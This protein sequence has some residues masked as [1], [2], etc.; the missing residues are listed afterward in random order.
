MKKFGI[1]PQFH[2]FNFMGDSLAM[3][4]KDFEDFIEDFGN[5]KNDS[6]S[7]AIP[8]ENPFKFHQKSME[9][10]MKMLEQQMQEMQ[11]QQQRFFKEDPNW[12]EF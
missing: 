6:L 4:Q 5:N 11:K 2:H 1:H 12:K 10:M 3:N 9:E 8:G 7:S